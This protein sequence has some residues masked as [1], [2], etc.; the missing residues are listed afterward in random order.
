VE[1]TRLLPA[2]VAWSEDDGPRW[3]LK[4]E[5]PDV[6]GVVAVKA[7][8]VIAP[9]AL[10][11]EALADAVC[12]AAAMGECKAVALFLDSPGGMVDGV[13]DAAARIA[14]VDKPVVAHTSALLCS[15]A[16]W[17]ASGADAILA[18][19]SAEVGSI[20]VFCPMMDFSAA[21]AEMGIGVELAKTGPLKG[22][23]FPGTQWTDAQKAHM[24]QMVEDVF[25]G[26]KGA[27]KSSRP[28]VADEALT[29]G[30]YMAA[31]AEKLGLADAVADR[32]GAMG[33][34]ASLAAAKQILNQ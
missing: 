13:E 32:T 23:G 16:Y 24:Q 29:G 7:Y 26:F 8:G 5:A 6:N 19:T 34:A 21:F 17:L 14:A 9:D 12:G 25:E 18:A 4:V 3:G 27:V 11:A 10:S 2:T 20:G 22:M 15:A 31:R 33:V 30:A 1:P 28:D